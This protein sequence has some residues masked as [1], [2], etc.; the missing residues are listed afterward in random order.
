MSGTNVNINALVAVGGTAQLTSSGSTLDVGVQYNNQSI[1]RAI[2]FNG[3]TLYMQSGG[4]NP[5]NESGSVDRQCQ[6]HI[7]V[8][9]S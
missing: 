4:A 8:L 3:L 7:L 2:N 1:A 6:Q 9:R 5:T